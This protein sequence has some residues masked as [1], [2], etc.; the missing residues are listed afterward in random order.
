MAKRN[1]DPWWQ[2]TYRAAPRAKVMVNR[3]V[4]AKSGPQAVSKADL[5][6]HKG[7]RRLARWVTAKKMKEGK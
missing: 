2:V 6:V 1:L 7:V 4:Q 5:L 3:V